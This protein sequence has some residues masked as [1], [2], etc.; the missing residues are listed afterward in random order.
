MSFYLCSNRLTEAG[1]QERGASVVTG[2]TLV[3]LGALFA[4]GVSVTTG[5]SV[6]ARVAVSGDGGRAFG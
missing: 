1:N 6:I 5:A 2:L 3:A 4:I